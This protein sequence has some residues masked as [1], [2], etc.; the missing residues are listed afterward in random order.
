M[1]TQNIEN[2]FE[3]KKKV[4]AVFFDLTA[5]YDTVCHRDLTCK[6]LRL[7]PDKHMV[8]MIME[9][10]RN[11]GFTLTT[12]DNKLSRLRRLKNGLPQGSVLAPLLFNIYVCD[13]LSITSKKLAYADD[14]AILYSSGIW[15]VL[16]RTLSKDMTTL[17][18][19]LH[20]WRLKLSLA[21]TVTAVFH[22]HNREAKRELKVKN[23][24]KVLPFCSVPTYL[25]VKLDRTLTYRDHLEALRKKLSTRVSLLRR[26]AISGWGAGAKILRLAALSLIYS[27]AE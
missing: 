21:K 6:L 2:S 17:S 19:Y 12:G 14:L 11:R 8:Q 27:T 16:G 23:N 25:C 18:A 22:L 1:F 3:A 26:L 10:V 9:L 20:A 7:V 24:G 13:L 4:G 15:K 5:A